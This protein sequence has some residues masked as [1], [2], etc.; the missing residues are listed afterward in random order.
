M[1][2]IMKPTL[3]E[4]NT[5][6]F[7][8][9]G[10]G[11]LI[12]CISCKVTEE[13]NGIYEL[14]AQYPQTGAHFDE[15]T[16]GRYI[17]AAAH[18]EKTYQ[19]FKIYSI[20][21]P[22]NGIITIKAEH[23]SYELAGNPVLGFS[24]SGTAG[25]MLQKLF[26]SGLMGNP[27]TA[28]TDFT[29]TSKI[30]IQQPNTIRGILGG[31]DGSFLDRFHGEFEFDNFHVILWANR[32]ADKG[33]TIEYGKN[34]TD[35]TQDEVIESTYTSIVP[36]VKRQQDGEETYIYIP[37]G[38][39]SAPN[40]GYFARQKA[41]FVDF[42][43]EFDQQEAVEVAKLRRLGQAYI[44]NNDVGT[45][46]VSLRV[47]FIDLRKTMQYSDLAPLLSVNLC[48]IVT[49]K[50]SALGVNTKAK[51]ISTVYDSLLEQYDQIE[52]GTAQANFV[53]Q[54][55]EWQQATNN[56]I[57]NVITQILTQTQLIT[58][59]K[60]GYV[61]MGLNE[62]GEP[63]EFLIMDTPDKNSAKNVWRWNMG[64]LGFSSNGYN[65]PFDKIA[66]TMDGRINAS[67]ITTGTLNANLIKT[68]SINAELITTGTLS[69]DRVSGGILTDRTGTLQINLNSGNIDLQ[70]ENGN[71]QISSFGIRNFNK[72]GKPTYWLNRLGLVLYNYDEGGSLQ[73]T[74]NLN[75]IG[76][77][78]PQV[79]TQ[80][81]QIDG[82]TVSWTYDNN[83]KK[84]ILTGA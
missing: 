68:G 43:S 74:I 3:Y 15:I 64:G 10:L 79:V 83:L 8:N 28:S 42:S 51:V 31:I 77:N 6:D 40:A 38:Y 13:R 82:K 44:K 21:R 81:L 67:M 62:F 78:S 17:K 52:L 11:T 56:G 59:N 73:D 49:V 72:D 2:D 29:G 16:V 70:G 60:G 55:A 66:I 71:T 47:S 7:N 9:D 14:Q 61:V 23:V 12:D 19:L 4:V 69:A 36:Y 58:G 39:L 54:Y 65:G 1:E 75:G 80:A 20:T 48:D 37:E 35:V 25:S 63:E 33:I 50:F 32:G 18:P 5:Q 24:A 41:F 34:L 45:P 84:Y 26:Q 27:F 76:L 46:K 30:S 53:R 57:G 22:L